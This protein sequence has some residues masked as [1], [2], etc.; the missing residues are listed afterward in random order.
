M[1]FAVDRAAPSPEQAAH[2]VHSVFS[3]PAPQFPQYASLI[4][5]RRGIVSQPVGERK[6]NRGSCYSA[7]PV[8][9]EPPPAAPSHAG[10]QG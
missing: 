10:P 1:A 9:I 4:V 8:K 7:P 3:P 2:A 6:G 5:P